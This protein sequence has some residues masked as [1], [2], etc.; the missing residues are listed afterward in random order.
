MYIYILIAIYIVPLMMHS[1]L[2]TNELRRRFYSFKKLA[3]FCVLL[4][5]F[6]C[7]P[8]M[9][10]SQSLDSMLHDENHPA[11]KVVDGRIV[12]QDKVAVEGE[13]TLENE[14]KK[15]LKKFQEEKAAPAGAAGPF[16]PATKAELEEAAK[17]PT[18]PEAAK[19]KAT[20]TS[21]MPSVPNYEGNIGLSAEWTGQSMLRGGSIG[22][23][24]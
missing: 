4:N 23:K 20:Q 21:F 3:M 14:A 22:P 18:D 17:A 13:D 16:F 1:S 6:V 8:P 15:D 10:S 24:G 7:G 2:S 11:P 5:V 12:D 9:V 19:A